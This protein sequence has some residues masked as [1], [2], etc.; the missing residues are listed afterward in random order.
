MTKRTWDDNNGKTWV[1][2][3]TRWR[4]DFRK[5]SHRAL[6]K[7]VMERDGFVCNTCGV[8]PAEIPADYDGSFAP[9]VKGD[10]YLVIDHIRSRYEGS[11]AY[12]HHPDN[13]Q[14]LCDGCNAAKRNRVD[15]RSR[16]G[17]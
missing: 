14:V 11:K 13:L 15:M 4:L 5:A 1:V 12:S 10:R 16:G 3:V 9:V 2:P 17:D 7:H 8:S 6:R